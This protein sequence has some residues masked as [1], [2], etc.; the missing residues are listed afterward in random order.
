MP[1]VR[2]S[3]S[4]SV[5][6]FLSFGLTAGATAGCESS[7]SKGMSD[8]SG[9]SSDTSA[10]ETSS[11]LATACTAP[12]ENCPCT[13]EGLTAACQGP[14]IH[15]GNYTSCAPGVSVCM[16]GT[17]S[18]C[19]GKTLYQD[20][21]SVS[22]DYAS[23]CAAGTH[24]RWGALTVQGA[25]PDDSHIVA[26]VQTSNT[27]AGLDVT[28]SELVAV[29]DGD[30][31]SAWKGVDEGAA[32][33]TDGIASGKMLRVTLTL[34]RAGAGTSPSVMSWQVAPTCEAN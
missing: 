19:L 18:A 26:A 20:V 8:G 31:T 24:V 15:V 1:I 4:T 25:T 27:T 3:F 6:M 12:S 30:A 13:V 33:A 28:A 5:L 11:A 14:Q 17:W 29:F 22:Q 10:M 2:S 9:T 32:L 21:D 16:A 34:E 23:P 7:V